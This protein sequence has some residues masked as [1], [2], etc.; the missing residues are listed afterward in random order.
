MSATVNADTFNGLSVK[1]AAKRLKCDDETVRELL[2]SRRI[3]GR[4]IFNRVWAI[5]NEELERVISA[6][7]VIRSR[8]RRQYVRW[9]EVTQ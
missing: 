6:R 2:R 8:G 7:K 1:D 9:P 4:L 3:H 5:T